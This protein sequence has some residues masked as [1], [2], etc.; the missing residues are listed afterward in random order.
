MSQPTSGFAPAD[1]AS[2]LPRKDFDMEVKS[3][4][5]AGSFELYAACFGNVDRGGDLIEPG[6]FVNLA[7]FVKDGWIALNHLSS[8]LPVGI[9][10]EA[11]QDAHGLKIRGRF[12]TTPSAQ[13][14]RIVVKE[15]MAAGK[16]VKCSIGYVTI[17]E[18][19]EKR[20]GR[21]VRHLKKLAVFEVSFVNLPMN[22]VAEVTSVKGVTPR[23]T[24][25][26]EEDTMSES[27]K[28]AVV[29]L[30]R[31]LGLDTKR[32]VPISAANRAK[33]AGHMQA[34][35]EAHD[36]H[37]R[38]IKEMG[39][40]HRKCVKAHKCS[41]KA[42]DEMKSCMKGFEPGAVDEDEEEDDGSPDGDMRRD[43]E[44]DEEVDR[45]RRGK[46]KKDE[47]PQDT[48]EGDPPKSGKLPS[49]NDQA[50]QVYRDQLKHRGNVGRSAQV[51][52]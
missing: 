45:G 33:I 52:P 3:L 13:E 36:E 42:L 38:C 48:A 47:D 34:V 32:S 20:D 30:K 4:D 44:G 9:P 35:E 17:E 40:C 22:P 41:M 25:P 11:A 23:A 28:G 39:E 8:S 50:L 26:E 5:D 43:R 18:S 6:A 27:E 2:C 7:E 31:L 19:Y 49:Q 21:T 15:R 29:A 16:A 24:G 12:H 1:A 10:D 51:C 14:C 37:D 46:G